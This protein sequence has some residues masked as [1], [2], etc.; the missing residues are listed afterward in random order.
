VD[1]SLVGD[2][3]FLHMR[4][5]AKDDFRIG[6]LPVILHPAASLLRVRYWLTL[7][8]LCCLSPTFSTLRCSFRISGIGASSSIFGGLIVGLRDKAAVLSLLVWGQQSPNR[9]R[10]TAQKWCITD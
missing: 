1:H 4:A 6:L 5:N 8:A 7:T 10:Y 9:K 2:V 3:G